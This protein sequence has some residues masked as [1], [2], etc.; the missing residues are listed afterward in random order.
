MGDPKLAIS[1]R[2]EGHLGTICPLTLQLPELPR[3]GLNSDSKVLIHW[4]WNQY[5]IE[6]LKL[7][8]F[9]SYHVRFIVK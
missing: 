1:V 5:I 7:L 4:I 8:I 6:I 3:S 9:L 2:S